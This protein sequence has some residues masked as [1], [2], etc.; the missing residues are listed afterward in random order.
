LLARQL[1]H[2]ILPVADA[3]GAPGNLAA[4]VTTILATS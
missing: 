1:T 2:Q 3:G 4:M